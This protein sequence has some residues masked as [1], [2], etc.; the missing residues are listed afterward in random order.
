MDAGPETS[1]LSW[2]LVESHE[3]RSYGLFSVS[4]NRC[5]SPRTGNVHEFQVLRSPDWV[6][7]VALT[8]D[9]KMVMVRQFRHGTRE[10]SL[11]PPGGLVKGGKT[12]EQSGLEELE[13][14]TGYRASSLELLGWMHPMPAL[15]T[16]RLY[17]YLAR[18]CQPTGRLDPDETEEVETV[19][20]PVQEVREYVR[21]GK[22][23]CGVM[24]A[25][26]HLFFDREGAR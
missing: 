11:E 14:E 20:V 10:L 15:F 9:D 19:L 22:I 6:A 26:L 1:K 18:D 13:E 12:P 23:R 8:S 2:E 21:S 7:V 25:A 5:R 24:I 17:V 4:I 16:N 3:D